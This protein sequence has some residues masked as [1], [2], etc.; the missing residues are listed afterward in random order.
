MA[1]NVLN[2]TGQVFVWL[3]ISQNCI[4][5]PSTQCL[6]I[7]AHPFLHYNICVLKVRFDF[8]QS[9]YTV[10]LQYKYKQ[11]HHV[12]CGL[13]APIVAHFCCDFS[14]SHSLVLSEESFTLAKRCCYCIDFYRNEGKKKSPV[15]TIEKTAWIKSK[16]RNLIKSW[17]EK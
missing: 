17:E 8:P 2:S 9:F 1:T 6:V 5:H 14:V 11:Y 3:F 16:R 13:L 12:T 15:S 7:L 4:V 10:W